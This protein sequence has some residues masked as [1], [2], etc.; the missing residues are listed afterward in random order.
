MLSTLHERQQLG[1]LACA[2]TRVT[3]CDDIA[4]AR[5]QDPL[6][7]V[8]ER[9]ALWLAANGRRYNCDGAQKVDVLIAG[10]NDRAIAIEVKLGT[11]GLSRSSLAKFCACGKLTHKGT[12]IGGKMFSVL[13]RSFPTDLHR[14]LVSAAFDGRNFVLAEP[15]WLVVRPTVYHR[16]PSDLPMRSARILLFDRLASLYGSESDFDS[17]VTDLVGDGFARRWQIALENRNLS[18]NPSLQRT[19]PGRSPGCGR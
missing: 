1:E 7:F 5:L 3:L 17:L 4:A 8:P 12:K 11:T 2:R 14:P 6:R 13:E 9:A 18:P 19:T 16:W 10:A 15:W